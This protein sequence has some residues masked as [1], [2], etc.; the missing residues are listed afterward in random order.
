VL[1]LQP[2]GDAQALRIVGAAPGATVLTGSVLGPLRGR[3]RAAPT[4]VLIPVINGAAGVKIR[5]AAP[6]RVGGITANAV[7]HLA[8]ASQLPV[9]KTS[10]TLVRR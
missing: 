2:S 10:K 9:V 5:L 4:P 8:A 6:F 7:D 1:Q 3:R